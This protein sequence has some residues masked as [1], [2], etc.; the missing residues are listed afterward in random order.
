MSVCDLS[1]FL[2]GLFLIGLF[3]GCET[4]LQKNIRHLKCQQTL[5]AWLPGVIQKATID[6][7][8]RFSEGPADGHRT[9]A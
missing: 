7:C 1:Q 4:V 5:F 9:S 8:K 3:L 2:I 6:L